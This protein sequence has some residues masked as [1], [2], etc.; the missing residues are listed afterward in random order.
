MHFTLS[1]VSVLFADGSSPN[2]VWARRAVAGHLK[3][4]LT[5]IA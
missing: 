4:E 1:K 2:Q 3:T 5:I